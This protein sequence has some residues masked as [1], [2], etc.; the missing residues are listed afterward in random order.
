MARIAIG[1]W[2][3]ETNTFAPIKA[4]LG[5]FQAGGEWPPLGRGP[6]MFD[7]VRGV[8]LPVTGALEVLT[9]L[10]HELKP[11]LWAAATPSAQVTETAYEA[12]CAMLLDDLAAAMPLDGVFLDLHGAM[13]CEHL[14]DGEGELLRRAREVVGDE[15]PIAAS[16]DLHANVTELM[17]E[18][19]DALDIYRTYPHV[20]MGETGARAARHL[21][22]LVAAGER[23]HAALRRPGF[24]IPL[25]WGCTMTEPAASIYAAI[26]QAI[27]GHVKALSVACGF[28]LADIREAGPA[29]L[30]YADDAA[31]GAQAADTFLA[32]FERREADFAGRLLSPEE[33]VAEALRIAGRG[34]GP[35]ILAD[36]QD[37]PGGGGPG[38]T[39]GL[40][41]ALVDGG[42]AG[43]VVAMIADPGA[44]E[45]AHGAGA[46]AHVDLALGE[47]SG[48]AGHHP[49]AGRFRV[50][51]LGDGKFTATGPMYRGARMDL[52]RMALLE[53]GGVRVIVSSRAAQVAD[54]SILRH[55]EVEPADERIIALKSSVHFRNDFQGIAAEI[56]V[57]T[58]P[59]PVHADP[60]RLAFERLRP[61]VRLRPLGT[62]AG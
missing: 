7:A 25:N 37:N 46:G 47:K 55:L 45:L 20:D 5:A 57:V 34:R 6:A 30:V 15:I 24:L 21:H 28:P 39:T 41:K 58:A 10:G 1:G 60:Q 51:R 17:V 50:L 38:D 12:I 61:G 8:H 36:T 23:W 62:P 2:Q 48:M 52:G 56:L 54:Q 27:G 53:I 32:E 40:L 26:P 22:R 9:G 49:Y 42:A 19:A 44:A 16:L 14:E 35:V 11:L 31:A 43:A 13:V 59:G 18:K 29:V 33:A 4:D 3:H